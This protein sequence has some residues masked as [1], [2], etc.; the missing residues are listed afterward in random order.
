[1]KLAKSWIH[2]SGKGPNQWDKSMWEDIA[3]YCELS[4]GMARTPGSLRVKWQTL[5][6]ESQIYLAAKQK[7]FGNPRS[8]MTT[9][10][11]E[12]L[13]MKLYCTRAGRKDEHGNDIFASP[14]RYIEAAEYLSVHPKFGGRTPEAEQALKDSAMGAI[15]AGEGVVDSDVDD[16]VGNLEGKTPEPSSAGGRSCG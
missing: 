16:E 9:G 1:M 4:L 5:Q 12:A 15:P 10:D 13:T 14:F 3:E 7:V 2:V 8:G 11:C 6:R